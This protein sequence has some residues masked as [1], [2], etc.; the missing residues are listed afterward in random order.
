V[1]QLKCKDTYRAIQTKIVQPDPR[2]HQER[3]NWQET[4][5]EKSGKRDNR[6]HVF[7]PM[8]FM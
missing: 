3:R 4:E 5:K 1:L 6:L 7:H 8:K 2:R